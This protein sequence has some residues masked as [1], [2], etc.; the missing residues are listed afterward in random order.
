MN[1][2]GRGN[3]VEDAAS[4]HGSS[5]RMVVQRYRHAKILIDECKEIFVGRPIRNLVGLNE[6][7]DESYMTSAGILAYISFAKLATEEKVEQC[8]RTLLN[9]PIL[10]LG[11]WGDG[12]GTSSI[13]HLTAEAFKKQKETL[14]S[15]SKIVG[16][17]DGAASPI[18]L[19]LVP[20]ANITAKVKKLG[21]S[22]QYRDQTS[23]SEGERLYAYF[24]QFVEKLLLEHHEA[25]KQGGGL[26]LTANP[27]DT[28]GAATTS[29][30][31]SKQ[32][33]SPDPSIPPGLLFRQ[34]DTYST[35][36]E[37]GDK[38]FPLTLSNGEPLTK[39]AKKKLQKIY[40][41]HVVRH[42]KYLV[43]SSQ[44][45]EETINQAGDIAKGVSNVS[46]ATKESS[47]VALS[48]T[49]KEDRETAM[50]VKLDDSF[51]QLI[52]GS[53]GKRQGIEIQSDMGPFCHIV[54][55]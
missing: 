10:T 33:T 51:I 55:I 18:S 31:K 30:N 43:T 44:N 29:G 47:S 49:G 8:A 6:D 17:R 14:K 25:V 52:S 53:F 5:I 45:N 19:L 23:K 50:T 42:Q 16:I 28:G 1:D 20:Q 38:I 22:I 48:Q 34:D 2:G 3:G 54:E 46:D 36:E 40:Q 39:S 27:G 21:K 13:L 15:S 9:L 32:P 41:A 4:A 35:F 12:K 11:A 7:D 26:H 24:C 37:E